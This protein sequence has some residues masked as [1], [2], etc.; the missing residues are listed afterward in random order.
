MSNFGTGALPG[1]GGDPAFD[2]NEVALAKG[3]S[4]YEVVAVLIEYELFASGGWTITRADL[5]GAS[6][7][8]LSG[9]IN[10]R[11]VCLGWMEKTGYVQGLRVAGLPIGGFEWKDMGG[12]TIMGSVG[13]HRYWGLTIEKVC[14]CG[15]TEYVEGVGNIKC[16]CN[17]KKILSVSQITN[18]TETYTNSTGD[19]VSLQGQTPKEAI[20]LI[21]NGETGPH[22]YQLKCQKVVV[23]GPGKS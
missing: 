13:R 18:T 10:K 6:W 1:F 23:P 8:K 3:K 11:C 12:G 19:E 9:N 14:E 7:G 17:D 16:P 22:G 20:E 4:C 21:V 5:G 2:R 15:N